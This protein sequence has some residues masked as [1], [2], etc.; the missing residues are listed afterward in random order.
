MPGR[1][2]GDGRMPAFS[3]RVP[4]RPEGDGKAA[5]RNQSGRDFNGLLFQTGK[6]NGKRGNQAF[7]HILAVSDLHTDYEANM[8]WTRELPAAERDILIVA[9]DVSSQLD[10]F[11]ATM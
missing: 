1:P 2:E 9:G 11:E 5:A 3:R 6:E 10:I 4:R 8:A 7:R